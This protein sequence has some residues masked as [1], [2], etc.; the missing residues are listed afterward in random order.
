[1]SVIKN[2][3][4]ESIT[5]EIGRLK[6]VTKCFEKY[7]SFPAKTIYETI[8]SKYIKLQNASGVADAMNE[9]GYRLQGKDSARKYISNDITS[10]FNKPYDDAYG[11]RALY[12]LARN[13]Y[14]FYKGKVNWNHIVKTCENIDN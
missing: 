13:I 9:M 2:M 3:T 7:S 1:M 8:F 4:S 5:F 6:T 10:I 14:F 11:N 12:I